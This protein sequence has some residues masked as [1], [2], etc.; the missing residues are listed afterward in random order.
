VNPLEL[1]DTVKHPAIKQAKADL[2]KTVDKRHEVCAVEGY[3]MLRQALDVGLRPEF[4]FF[5]HP[6]EVA[7][8]EA[9]A[10]DLPSNACYRVT[11]G[12]FSR[13]LEL[14]YEN[15]TDVLAGIRPKSLELESAAALLNER[16]LVLVGDRIQ[17]PRNVGVIV[18]NADAWGVGLAVFGDSADAHSRA[19]VRSSTGSI[20]RVPVLQ[21]R[22]LA[23]VLAHLK[24]R[25]FTVVGSSAAATT[26]LDR[27]V[28]KRPC[29][30]LVG[31]ETEGLSEPLR[32]RCDELVAIPM[33]GGAHS[34]NVTV[35]CGVLLYEASRK[36]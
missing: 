3:G 32:R 13:I 6:I 29:V 36:L 17:D 7:A 1:I 31:N 27:A 30:V 28:F 4:V 33:F 26:P 34:L 2:A 16:S 9:V 22:D 23:S 20:L 15:A 25:G 11:P 5:R 24:Q 35:A 18:R 12:V 14:G 10:A 21:T 8:F 19:G